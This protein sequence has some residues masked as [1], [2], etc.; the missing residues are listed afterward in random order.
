MRQLTMV[1]ARYRTYM[2]L[3]QYCSSTLINLNCNKAVLHMPT[4]S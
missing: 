3:K 1:Q 4:Y 2:D